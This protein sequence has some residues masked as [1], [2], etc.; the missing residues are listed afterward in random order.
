L[1]GRK[2]QA[3][4]M[5]TGLLLWQLPGQVTRRGHSRAQVAA[6]AWRS[7]AG[8]LTSLA[9]PWSVLSWEAPTWSQQGRGRTVSGAQRGQ[10]RNLTTP[11]HQAMC[12]E[13]CCLEWEQIPPV[14][15]VT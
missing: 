8:P 4:P 12:S 7:S 6:I 2:K 13:G 9:Q 14:L 3:I 11:R 1:R 5:T 15:M 10:D